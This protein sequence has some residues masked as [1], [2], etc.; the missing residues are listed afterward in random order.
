MMRELE[1][2]KAAMECL[3]A[4]GGSYSELRARLGD[5]GA[6]EITVPASAVIEACAQLVEER[7]HRACATALRA[8]RWEPA[9]TP[10]A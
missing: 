10:Q 1:A 9:V 5:E 3:K 7:G 8:L 2:I 6:E 4:H